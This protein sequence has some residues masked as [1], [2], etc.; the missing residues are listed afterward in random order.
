MRR[1][2]RLRGMIISGEEGEFVWAGFGRGVG[3]SCFSFVLVFWGLVYYF[4]SPCSLLFYFFFLSSFRVFHCFFLSVTLG[5]R[6][7]RT[8]SLGRLT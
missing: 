8:A 4:P 6:R 5:K 3:V 1:G 2:S 7:W